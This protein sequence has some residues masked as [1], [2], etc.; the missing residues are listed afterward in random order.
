MDRTAFVADPSP[1]GGTPDTMALTL[2]LAE[3][4][5]GGRP[6]PGEWLKAALPLV[7]ALL[8]GAV[9]LYLFDRWRKR[10]ARREANASNDQLS[11]FRSLYEEGEMS[12]EEFERVKALL[13]GQ[14]RQELNVPAPPAP[15]APPAVNGTAPAD[16]NVQASPPGPQSPPPPEAPPA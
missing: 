7:G 11:H 16:T 5:P 8:V 10:A 6:P 9:I 2:L 4:A 14:L 13:S 1:R 15:E 12:R 3:A